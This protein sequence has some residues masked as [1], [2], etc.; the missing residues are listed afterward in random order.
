MRDGRPRRAATASR[1]GS[2]AAWRACAGLDTPWSATG[3]ARPRPPPPPLPFPLIHSPSL[4]F[5]RPDS[6][7]GRATARH[8]HRR[9]ELLSLAAPA[10]SLE[11]SATSDST[12]PS[13]TP[14]A[15]STDLG[16]LCSPARAHRSSGDLSARVVLPLISTIAH[17]FKRIS[18]ASTSH[19]FP[20]PRFAL[21]RTEMAEPR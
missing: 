16:T 8:C 15:R 14:R 12:S 1:Q 2:A 19:T 18:S 3:S 4:A 20:R 10:S 9:S 7:S 13:R 5:A 17:V 11:S 6:R 21:Y